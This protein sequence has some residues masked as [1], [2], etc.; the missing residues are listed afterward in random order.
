MYSLC[1]STSVYFAQTRFGVYFIVSNRLIEAYAF[2][3]L[4]VLSVHVLLLISEYCGGPAEGFDASLTLLSDS[5]RPLMPH[6]YHIHIH[7]LSS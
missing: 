6:I 5:R 1:K 7:Y 4:S 2:N 3:Y